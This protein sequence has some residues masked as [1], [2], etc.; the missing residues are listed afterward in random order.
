[1]AR[2]R[3]GI[4]SK[5]PKREKLSLEAFLRSLSG[6]GQFPLCVAWELSDR[7]ATEGWKVRDWHSA[8]YEEV[9]E[10]CHPEPPLPAWGEGSGPWQYVRLTVIATT[11]HIG[12][13]WVK[14]K[15]SLRRFLGYQEGKIQLGTV[16]SWHHWKQ[17]W[18]R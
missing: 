18:L 14:L 10:A 15:A 6:R 5:R 8:T 2:V 1:M 7:K 12:F 9:T 11:S 17:E 16:G 13:L 4:L 3:Y